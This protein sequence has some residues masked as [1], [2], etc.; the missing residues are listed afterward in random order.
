MLLKLIIEKVLKNKT[1][2]FSSTRETFIIISKHPSLEV[3]ITYLKDV[4]CVYACILVC[5]SICV[6]VCVCMCVYARMS[7]CVYTCMC[8][9]LC[10]FF[11]SPYIR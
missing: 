2:V 6:C 10:V 11:V 4:M 3:T 5:V 1:L 9:C 7:V 8:M